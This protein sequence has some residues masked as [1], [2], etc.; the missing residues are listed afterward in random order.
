MFQASPLIVADI[1]N[2]AMKLAFASR[3]SAGQIEF[4]NKVQWLHEQFDSTQ[5]APFTAPESATWC[6][7]SV[8]RGKASWLQHIIVE[9]LPGHQRIELTHHE[10]PLKIEVDVPEKVGIDRL[11]TAVAVN[12]RRSANSA[13]ITITA[14]TAVTVNAIS[15]SGAFLGGAILPGWPLLAKS[16][17]EYTDALPFVN[18]L[19]ADQPAIGKNTEAAIRSGLYFGLRGAVEAIVEE[20]EETCDANME[21]FVAGGDS[22]RLHAALGYGTLAPDLVLEGAAIVALAQAEKS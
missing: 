4:T 22:A 15:A 8:H 19:G 9:L 7:S 20:F 2:S 3:N 17:H 10:L 5:L 11:L 6:I 18:D 16:L 12:S 14:G 13:A 21:V 1:G